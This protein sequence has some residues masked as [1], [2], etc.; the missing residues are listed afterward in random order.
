MDR[1]TDTETT[2]MQ[3][4]DE[5]VTPKKIS[6]RFMLTIGGIFIALCICSWLTTPP[7]QQTWPILLP[8]EPGMSVAA[9]TDAAKA[10]HLVRSS[11]VLYTLL[12]LSYDPTNIYAG[13]YQFN[14]SSSVFR[15]A[16]KLASGT[17]NDDSVRVTIPEGM[18]IRDIAAIVHTALP[19][20]TETMYQ[21]AAAGKEGYLY[22]E[23]YLIPPQFTAADIVALQEKTFHERTDDLDTLV[24]SSGFSKDEVLTLASIVEREANDEASMK[25][26]AGIFKNRLAI[27]MAL[28]ADATLEYELTTPL[29]EL[30]NHEVAESLESV[31][32]PYNTYKYPGLP[33]TPI[34]NPGRTALD[35]VLMSTPSSYLYYLTDSAG[36]FHYAETFEEHKQNIERYLK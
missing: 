9:I 1:T 14:E 4:E 2:A 7:P 30:E 6:R 21:D 5:T 28:Q 17:I 26:V 29:S 16:K 12:T 19:A 22:P 20:I 15:V 27:G 24:Q 34:G 33:P 35:A 3:H 36:I 8:I 10:A 23:T 11:F 18:R 13:T 31:D 32:S 25:M